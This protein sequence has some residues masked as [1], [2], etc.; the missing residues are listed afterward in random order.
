MGSLLTGM[1]N[2]RF[3]WSMSRIC[4]YSVVHRHIHCKVTKLCEQWPERLGLE[5]SS[6]KLLVIYILISISESLLNYKIV[7]K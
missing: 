3:Q 7:V 2:L 4:F 5:A 1:K 6:Y